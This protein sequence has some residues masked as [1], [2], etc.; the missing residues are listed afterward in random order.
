MLGGS[1][2]HS[3]APELLL[4]PVLVEIGATCPTAALY[5]LDSEFDGGETLDSWLE[6]ARPLVAA[7]TKGLA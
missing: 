7:T 3:L 5:L 4:R 6:R 2:K 1:W